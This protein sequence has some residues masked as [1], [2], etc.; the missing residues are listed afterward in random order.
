[1]APVGSCNS[2]PRSSCTN[3]STVSEASPGRRGALARGYE[4][5]FGSSIF[6]VNDPTPRQTP[7]SS[8]KPGVQSFTDPMNPF[9]RTAGKQMTKI[10]D[11]RADARRAGARTKDPSVMPLHQQSTEGQKQK[12]VA[13]RYGHHEWRPSKRCPD[14]HVAASSPTA[15]PE[16]SALSPRMSE[17]AT[18]ALS[19]RGGE[20]K[21]L[22]NYL[23]DMKRCRVSRRGLTGAPS[24]DLQRM[25]AE[26]CVLP[27]DRKYPDGKP[28]RRSRS[29]SVDRSNNEESTHTDLY[30]FGRKRPVTG[31]WTSRSNRDLLYHNVESVAAATPRPSERAIKAEKR[32]DEMV[33]HIKAMNPDIQKRFIAYKDRNYDSVGLLDN[34]SPVIA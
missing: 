31:Q 4:S 28:W 14:A 12:F 11:I 27:T 32:F 6:Q 29:L 21:V 17:G 20:N 33:S 24:K 8:K 18:E 7:R 25:N 15:A 13:Y 5:R 9:D 10:E 30:G 16:H 26:T 34:C 23:N 19:G 1:M 22:S 3:V 2:S